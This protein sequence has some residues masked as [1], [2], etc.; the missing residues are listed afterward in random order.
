[1]RNQDSIQEM[2]EM[3]EKDIENL[4]GKYPEEFFPYEGLVLVGQQVS[5]SGRRFDLMFKD[6]HNRKIIVEIKRGLLTRESSGQIVEY[7]GLLKTQNVSS[8][9]ELI[10]VA[11][12]IPSERRSFLESVGISCKEISEIKIRLIAEKFKYTFTDSELNIEPAKSIIIKKNNS[13]AENTIRKTIE[14]L[15]DHIKIADGRTMIDYIIKAFSETGKYKCSVEQK[16]IFYSFSVHR[17]T[18]TKLIYD[19]AFIVNRSD[20]LFY[21][22]KPGEKWLSQRGL[23]NRVENELMVLRNNKINEMTIRVNNMNIAKKICELLLNN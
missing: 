2:N 1:M 13:I 12:S 21:I 5:I 17:I 18:E 22:R 20:L 19:Y 15:Y 11:N 4:I 23:L 14:D 8:N 10:L 9:I 16:K 6:K 3:L 7:Y